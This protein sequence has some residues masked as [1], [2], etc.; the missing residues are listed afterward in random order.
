M[1]CSADGHRPWWLWAPRSKWWSGLSALWWSNS[2]PDIFQNFLCSFMWFYTTLLPPSGG[3]WE[4]LPAPKSPFL[5]LGVTSH[6][7]GLMDRVSF[8]FSVLCAFF[9]VSLPCRLCYWWGSCSRAFPCLLSAT[10]LIFAWPCIAH[11]LI[12]NMLKLC[13]CRTTL[14]QTSYTLL[15]FTI[16]YHTSSSV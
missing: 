2:N 1:P 16:I 12:L 7:F 5:V 13:V 9:I 10:T 3:K 6:G 11:I 8:L 15:L 4:I 14:L